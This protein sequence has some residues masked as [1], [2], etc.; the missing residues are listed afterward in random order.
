MRTK[1][2]EHPARQ[3]RV[4]GVGATG[5]PV[6]LSDLAREARTSPSTASR[7]LRGQ[8]YVSGE[9]RTR[10]L[11]AAERL[12]YVPN[13]SA[14]NL[15]HRTS[16]IIG[17]VVS[18]LSNQFYARVAAGIEAELRC[19][20]YQMMLVGDHNDDTEELAAARSFL[21]LRSPGVII[22]PIRP[23]VSELLAARGVAVVEVDR[24]LSPRSCDAV[25]LDN[26]TGAF[27]A[28]SH[29]LS[30]GH[31]RVAFIGVETSWTSDA[32]RRLGYQQAHE[33]ANLPSDPA[34]S[35]LVPQGPGSHEAVIAEFLARTQPTALFIG[36]N[37][38][39]DHTWRVLRDRGDRLPADISLVA[40]DD[41][42]WMDMVTPTITVV[43]QPTEELG[44]RAAQLCLER[45]ADPTLP[46]R[47]VEIAPNLLLRGSTAPVA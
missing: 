32:G 41:L 16:K 11:A 13:A 35:L 6:T 20:G 27:A 24:Q 26:V 42:P 15:K 29:L 31:R 23:T 14:Q 37:A 19:S 21:A 1:E 33:R 47:V 2:R 39:A 38:L 25:V 30:L 7:A 36:N 12:G 8:G 34:L 46:R 17:V 18:D 5:R 44:R 28:T 45:I 40:F 3:S 4:R 9:V 43:A 22:T 10:L